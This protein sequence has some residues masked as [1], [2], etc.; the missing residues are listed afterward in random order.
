MRYALLAYGPSGP[1]AEPSD[2]GLEAELAAA[3]ALVTSEVLADVDTAS[4]V[5]VRDAATVADGPF[6]E[7]AEVLRGVLLVD[8]P[9]L[10]AALA[11][12]RRCPAART[13][14]VEVRPVLGAGTR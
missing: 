4:T 11:V 7:T 5:R 2:I 9:D 6:A 1:W 8:L 3:G 12:A 10:D 14:S 13:G